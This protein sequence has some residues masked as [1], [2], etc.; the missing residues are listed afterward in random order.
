MK[1]DTKKRTFAWAFGWVVAG[2][3]CACGTGSRTL[4]AEGFPQAETLVADSVV[5]DEVLQPQSFTV[6]ADY[7]VLFSPKTSKVLWRYRLP[8]WTLADSSFVQGG[9]PD[10]FGSYVSF[11]ETSETSEPV[12]WLTDVLHRCAVRF[13]Q[14]A[15]ALVKTAHKAYPVSGSALVVGDT[16]LAYPYSRQDALSTFY[17]AAMRDTLAVL[18]SVPGYSTM[19]MDIQQE[20]GKI[21]SISV[22]VYNTVQTAVCGDRIALWYPG[23]RHLQVYRVADGN[24][25]EL[26]GQYGDGPLDQAA[27]DAYL[28]QAGTVYSEDNVGLLAVDG[29]YLYFLEKTRKKEE[30]SSRPGAA[31][32]VERLDIKVYDWTMTPVRKYRLDHPTAEKM[33]PD[34]ANGK[35]YAWDPRLDFEQV[36]VYSL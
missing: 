31:P 32:T 9:G 16:L 3:L 6:S 35:V 33:L 5:I 25:L 8:D 20:G 36:Y 1:I 11:L 4:D 28:A 18:D 12:F 26:V 22:R 21:Q 29:K 7:A 10:D 15:G 27:V 19:K 23:T 13:D 17:L 30:D 34:V 14:S 2:G 24:R